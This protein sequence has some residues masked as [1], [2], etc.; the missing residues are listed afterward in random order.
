MEAVQSSGL[1]TKILIAIVAV[2]VVYMLFKWMTGTGELQDTL[3]YA[4]PKPGLVAHSTSATIYSF[5]NFTLPQLYGGGEFTVSTWI[6]V[7]NWGTR[8]GLNKVF[9]SLTGGGSGTTAFSTMVMYLGQ[10]TNKLGVRVSTTDTS[11]ITLT[12]MNLIEAGT[13]PYSDVAGDF[14]NCDINNVDLQRWVCITAV[15]SGRILDIYMDGKLSRSCVLDGMYQL[16]G[17]NSTLH[18]GGSYGFGGYIGQTRVANYAYS[19]DQVYTNYM[20]G[21][22]SSSFFGIL[23]GGGSKPTTAPPPPTSS[24]TASYT[25]P[26]ISFTMP[27]IKFQ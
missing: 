19:P 16:D 14:K 27:S 15:M 2:V 9:L 18:L 26:S 23:G 10:N 11:K 17:D 13:T 12:Q 4:G 20:N 7:N 8:K 5:N 21:P 6:Y 24:F 1:V 25:L 22:F 3:V